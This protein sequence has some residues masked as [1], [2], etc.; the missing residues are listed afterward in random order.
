MLT[1]GDGLTDVNI[2]NIV[3]FHKEHKKIVTITGVYPPARFGELSER[4]GK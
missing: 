2:N 4:E 3:K 1:Y